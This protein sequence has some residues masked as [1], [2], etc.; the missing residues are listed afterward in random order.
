MKH[1]KYGTCFQN[2]YIFIISPLNLLKHY[3]TCSSSRHVSFNNCFSRQP[4]QWWG[5][6]VYQSSY[7]SSLITYKSAVDLHLSPVNNPASDYSVNGSN[8]G[9]NIFTAIS[10]DKVKTAQ[11][12]LWWHLG[13]SVNATL[14]QPS[15]NVEPARSAMT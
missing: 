8:W 1:E 14:A 7:C 10:N 6:W 15:G 12:V 2:W 4:L 5:F 13:L 11:E 9:A 3:W